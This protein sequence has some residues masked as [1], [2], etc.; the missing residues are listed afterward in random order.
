M[1][2]RQFKYLC[3]KCNRTITVPGRVGVCPICGSRLEEAPRE[4]RTD[5]PKE[6]LEWQKKSDRPRG[7]V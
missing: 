7:S 5:R 2:V 1:L 6:D 4:V 3:K